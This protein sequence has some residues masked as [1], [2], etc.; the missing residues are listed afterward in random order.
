MSSGSARRADATALLRRRPGEIVQGRL[1]GPSVERTTF[2]EL[3]QMLLADYEINQRKSIR[4][5]RL[6]V[7]LSQCARPAVR[8]YATNE[9]SD[10]SA[11]VHGFSVVIDI[12]D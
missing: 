9:L 11:E 1:V 4:R 12:M 2:E 8:R 6:S 5:V 3:T 7:R 10:T